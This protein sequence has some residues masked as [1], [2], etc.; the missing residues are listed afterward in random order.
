M[1]TKL[2][3]KILHFAN[4][5]LVPKKGRNAID[6]G[7]EFHVRNMLQAPGD[8]EENTEAKQDN[9]AADREQIPHR[10][11]GSNRKCHAPAAG[12]KR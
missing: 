1:L 10:H 2:F 11:P 7:A 6:P 12:D 8:T 3:G 4:G 9:N 5:K